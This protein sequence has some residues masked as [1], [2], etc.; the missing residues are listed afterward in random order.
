MLLVV[1]TGHAAPPGSIDP[2]A[3][4]VI[5]R[6]RTT[7]ATYTIYWRVRYAEGAGKPDYAWGAT[8]RKGSLVRVEDVQ[9]RAVVDCAAVK[10]T[11]FNLGVG[12]DN[13]Q[14]G[15]KVAQKYCGI[16]ADRKMRAARWL[17]QK[18]GKVGLVD[19]VEIIDED[20][21][22]TYQVAAGGELV[23]VT[24]KSRGT[25]FMVV[26]EPMSMEYG[27]PAGDL[28]SRMSLAR[29][30]VPKTVQSRASRAENRPAN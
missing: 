29:S 28:F 19:E 7:T 13:Y 23:G 15:K 21:T 8:F 22:F 4:E 26:A 1:A 11:Q 5:S 30:Q 18:P 12:R 16:D 20:G 17:G 3:E 6:S 9:S 10:G 2:K 27:V 24:S 14:I 25:N